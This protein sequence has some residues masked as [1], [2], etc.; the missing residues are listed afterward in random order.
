MP[1][2]RLGNDFKTIDVVCRKGHEVAQY[3][4]P[5]SEWGERTH[6]LWLVEERIK[7]L[8]TVPP[9]LIADGQGDT[10]L[11]IPPTGTEIFCGNPE[12]QLMVGEI[13]LV[14]GAA[15]LVLEKRNLHPT[16]G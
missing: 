15:A 5:R 3:R 8:K 11:Q 10:S 16:K 12:C 6:K 9:I 1:P 2:K 4:K 13:G 14:A 7:R